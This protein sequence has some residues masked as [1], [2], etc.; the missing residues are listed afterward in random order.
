LDLFVGEGPAGRRL[1]ALW[2]LLLQYLAYRFTRD[3]LVGLV[4]AAWLAAGPGGLSAAL[5]SP[6]FLLSTGA[7]GLAAVLLTVWLAG[8]FLDRRPFRDFGFRLGGGWW[9]DLVFGMVLGAFLMTGVFLFGRAMGWFAVTG[10]FEPAAP[11]VPFVIGLAVPVLFFAAVGIGEETLYRG[12]Q[13]HNAAEGLNHPLLGPRGAVLAAWV[14]SSVS[15]GIPHADNPN[16][17]LVSTANIVLA[18]LMLGLGYVLTGDLAIPIG[19]HTTWNLF[20]GN[21]YGFPVSGIQPPGA[22]LLT[23]GEA[24][25][26]LW[27]G[28]AFGPEAGLLGLAAILLGGVLVALWVRAR[29]GSVRVETSLAE[30]P[31]TGAGVVYSRSAEDYRRG[32]QG[33]T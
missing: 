25:P 28:G 19:L 23:T 2:R 21:V 3:L 29:R 17:T 5:D 24:G 6:F 22:S 15:F 16:A 12:Y 8:R 13:L 10:A 18:G 14:V 11:G 4:V 27:T 31:G 20:Q 30:P 1:R 32:G 33:P 7:A 26:D 9:L